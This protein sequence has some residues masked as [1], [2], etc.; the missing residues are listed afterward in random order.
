MSDTLSSDLASLRIDRGERDPN[1]K[2]PWAKVAGFVLVAVAIGG[3][4]TLARPAL[5][6]RFFKTEIGVTEVALVSP[7][8]AQVALTASGYVVAQRVSKVGAKVP[9]RVSAIHVREGDAVEA[10]QVVLELE[11]DDHTANVRAAQA[12]AAAAQARV[13]T[14]RAQLVEAQIIAGRETRLAESGVGSQAAAENGQ[15]RVKSLEQ[16]V[17]ATQAEAAAAYAEARA[18]GVN[19]EYMKIVSPIS[20]RVLS[21]PPELG[22]L[23]GALT[24]EPLSIEIADFD[25]LVVECDV[26]EGRLH[27]VQLGTPAEIILDAFPGR[28]YRGEATEVSPKVNRQKAT[29]L[30]KV[31]FVDERTDVLPNMAARVSFLENALDEA[32]LKEPPKVVIPASAVSEHAG[33]KVVFL[34]DGDKVRMRPVQLGQAT[35][36]GFEVLS[37]PDPGTRLVKNPPAGLVDGQRIKEKE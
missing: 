34:L 22:E 35:A 21:K 31:K 27:L 32:S 11:S 13:E 29:V 12:R 37:G 7:A 30:V 2:G 8:Q 4:V 24:L 26:P 28:R 19:L 17:K 23:V 3:A 25:S 9:G 5:E 14:M 1:R 15:A 33:G 16:Q 18:L 10:G 6:A 20:G 36:G